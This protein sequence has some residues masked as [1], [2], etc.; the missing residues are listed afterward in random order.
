MKKI[1]IPLLTLS[2]LTISCTKQDQGQLLGGATGALIGS[3]FGGGRGGNAAGAG[4]G[5][6]LGSYLG[7]KIGASM[8]EQDKMKAQ[9]NNQRALESSRSGATST[10]RNPDNGHH[11]TITPYQAYQDNSSRYCREY[12]QTV[13]VGGKTE[14]AYGTACRQPDGSWN[15]VK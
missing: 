1:I 8:D 13:T 9:L 10:W 12:S 3:Q 11:G 14:Q 5:A 7:G 6:I 4:I 2:L 15:I